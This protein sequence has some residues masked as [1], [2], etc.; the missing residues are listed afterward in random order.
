MIAPSDDPSRSYNARWF[1]RFR[2]GAVRKTLT[3]MRT[4]LPVG[5]CIAAALLSLSPAFAE[6]TAPAPA[7]I[8]RPSVEELAIPLQTP[9][10]TARESEAR[11]AMCLM[12][13][14]AAR[15]EN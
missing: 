12:I 3:E 15:A 8:A 7:V 14:S 5:L 11:E 9:S 10:E 2:S 4:V 13:E 6:D 1:G